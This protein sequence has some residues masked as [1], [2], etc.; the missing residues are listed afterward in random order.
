MGT[1]VLSKPILCTK[2]PKVNWWQF[3]VNV[4]LFGKNVKWGILIFDS[5]LILCKEFFNAISKNS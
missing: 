1:S 3:N 5:N 4:Q 2:P